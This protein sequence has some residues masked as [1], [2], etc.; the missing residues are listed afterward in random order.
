MLLPLH[1]QRISAVVLRRQ[2]EPVL[3]HKLT[4]V[5]HCRRY[6]QPSLLRTLHRVNFTT[7]A[8]PGAQGITAPPP[9]P[10][11]PGAG[12]PDPPGRVIPI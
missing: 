5:Y 11:P 2:L 6:C 9:P 1:C 8:V 4:R 3:G 7:A 12:P 10:P